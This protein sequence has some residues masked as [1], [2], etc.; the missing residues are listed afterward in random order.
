MQNCRAFVLRRGQGR[1]GGRAAAGEA[2]GMQ[3]GALDDL[4]LRVA[5]MLERWAC[6]EQAPAWAGAGDVGGARRRDHD[7]GVGVLEGGRDE[8]EF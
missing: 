5:E 8:L 3:A 4:A 6:E 7:D 1:R 2:V